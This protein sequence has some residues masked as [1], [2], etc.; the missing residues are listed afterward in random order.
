MHI[1]IQLS[2]PQSLLSILKHRTVE[3]S[4]ERCEFVISDGPPPQP[5]DSV[6]E[7]EQEEDTLESTLVLR[8]HCQHGMCALTH[9][10]F[11]P[12]LILLNRRC[13]NSSTSAA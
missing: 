7:D 12:I 1:L 2:C 3:K 5:D 11:A 8:L 9:E 6:D 10:V 4:V 13:Q